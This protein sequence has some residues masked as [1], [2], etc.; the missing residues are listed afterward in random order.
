MS[1]THS[2]GECE[3]IWTLAFHDA[4]ERGQRLAASQ[5]KSDRERKRTS[6]SHETTSFLILSCS[7]S[8]SP[9]LSPFP[10]LTLQAS[11]FQ[12]MAPAAITK[13]V[14]RQIIDSR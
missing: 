1:L 9:S 4:T 2:S 5:Q 12:K 13:V 14:G 11:T 7:L 3:Q 8:L 6:A 10:N